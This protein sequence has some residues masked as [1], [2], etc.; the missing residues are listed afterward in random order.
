MS[1]VGVCCSDSTALD[2]GG[3]SD[4]DDM[5]REGGLIKLKDGPLHVHAGF[6]VPI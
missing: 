6:L 3:G 5:M 4:H 2:L 1:S